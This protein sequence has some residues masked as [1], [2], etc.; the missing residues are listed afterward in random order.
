MRNDEISLSAGRFRVL[1]GECEYRTDMDE[2]LSQREKYTLFDINFYKLTPEMEFIALC[3]H[4]YKDMN[5]IYLLSQRGLKLGLLWDI[6]FYVR[7]VNPSVGKIAMLARKLNVAQYIYICLVHAMEIFADPILCSYIEILEDER[8][9]NLLNSFG[10]NDK[11]RKFWDI[12]LVERLF[13]VNLPQYMQ[14]FLNDEDVE[15]IRINCES[16]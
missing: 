5:S 11:E 10:L 14:R 15:K 13:N 8:N 16:M 4:H 7:N 3:L 6:Y 1:W 2:V 12:S 9:E